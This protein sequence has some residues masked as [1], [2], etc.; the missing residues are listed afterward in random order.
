MEN[1]NRTSRQRKSIRSVKRSL[2]RELLQ[3]PEVSGLGIS[4]NDH[5]EE[6]ITI[7]LSEDSGAAR[8][9]VPGD[10]EGYPVVAEVV[11]TIHAASGPLVE[12]D[13]TTASQ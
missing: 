3:H 9:L 11:G 2:A 13:A 7:Y 12:P 1:D 5:G 4:E 8:A 10:C 6:Q